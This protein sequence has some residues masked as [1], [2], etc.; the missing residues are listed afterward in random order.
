MDK[1]HQL[2]DL[3]DTEKLQKL[4][5]MFAQ[6]LDLAFITVDYRGHPVIEYSGFTDFCNTIRKEERCRNLCYQCDA[7]GG[8]HATITGEPYIYRCHGG[9]VDFAVPLIL[10]G[11]YM[12]A[13][14]G[15]QIELLGEAPDLEPILPQ[16]SDRR[17]DPE[18]V[19]ARRRVHK[20]TYEKLVASVYLVRDMI[21][22]MLEEEYRKVTE[23]ELQKKNQELME[24]KAAR[25]NLEE[26][27]EDSK[28]AAYQEHVGGEYLFY[29]L[30]VIARLAFRERAEETERAVCDFAA[31]LRYITENSNNNFVTVGEELEYI[32][33]YL[34][35]QKRRLEGRLAYEIKVP[36]VYHGVLCPFM[37]L[38]PLVENS[39]KY[40]VEPSQEGGMLA[41]R[42][43]VEGDQFALTISDS[44]T[45]M[46]RQQISTLLELGGQRNGGKSKNY[47]TNINRRIKDV[48]GL[49][50]GVTIRSKEDGFP[51]TEVEI[52][53]P[54]TND[55]AIK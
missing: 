15:G 17:E 2:R 14:M 5:D 33:Y 4:Q 18:L 22:S 40:A 25:I 50:C 35:L 8:L 6:A 13:V 30:N 41:I 10:E 26:E 9:L 1:G 34:R 3:L 28:S 48:F 19:D 44:G 37:L 21:Q 16:I 20:V 43:R 29:M 38:Q 47:L 36:E 51:G 42:G 32:D 53:L 7:H 11:K 12:G 39:L 49:S 52:R 27:I 54:L 46:S 24:E 45:G 55:S 23:A 31:M